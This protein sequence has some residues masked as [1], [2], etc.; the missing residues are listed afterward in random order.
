MN[1]FKVRWTR[2]QHFYTVTYAEGEQEIRNDPVKHGVFGGHDVSLCPKGEF[3]ITSIEQ[4]RV[5]E[6][7]EDLLDYNGI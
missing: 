3:E 1:T 6:P 2:T 5:S 7:E 4:V